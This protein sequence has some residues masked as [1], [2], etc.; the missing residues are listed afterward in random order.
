M[1]PNMAYYALETKIATKKGHILNKND[2]NKFI[3]SDSV[4]QLVQHLKNNTE[5]NKAFTEF[6]KDN[7]ERDDLESLLLRFKT[8][9]VENLLHYFSGPYKEFIKTML[10]EAEIQDLSLILRKI[11]RGESLEEIEQR[12]IH[13]KIYSNLPFKE[14]SLSNSFEQ[15]I[16]NLKGTLYY[17]GLSNLSKNDALTREFHIEMKMYLVFYKTLFEKAVMLDKEDQKAV[18][19]VAGLKIDLLNIQWIYR[20]KKYYNISTEEMFNY[21]LEGGKNIDVLRLKKLCYSKSNDEFNILVHDYLGYDLF[22]D[23]NDGIDI[24][25]VIDS[26]M[27]NFLKRKTYKNIGTIISFI[28]LLDT[29]INDLTSITEGIIYKISKE[30]LKSYLAY[31]IWREETLDGYRKNG[32]FKNYRSTW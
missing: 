19:E 1:N 26:Y 15:A 9:E 16:Q 23:L 18:K 32:S 13:S 8:L 4:E 25:I 6:P 29:V 14:I 17:N 7:F 30:K 10:M 2:W 5:F 12:F 24:N 22:K 3:E 27:F 28:F 11:A 21:S 20:A 31:N